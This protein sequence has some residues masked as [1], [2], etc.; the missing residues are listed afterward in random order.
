MEWASLVPIVGLVMLVCAIVPLVWL[1]LRRR[2][3]ARNGG[4]F[5]CELNLGTIADPRWVLGVLRYSGEDLEW[6]RVLALSFRPEHSLRRSAARIRA[7]VQ[8]V[9]NGVDANQ[10]LV[11]LETETDAGAV[12]W[13]LAMDADAATGLLAWLEAAPPSVGRFTS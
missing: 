4:I 12:A 10:R 9:V 3:L 5:D 13:D 6:F 2:W 7:K 1:F 11:R 8:P